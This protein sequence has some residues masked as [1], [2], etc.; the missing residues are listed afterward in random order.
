V[1]KQRKL[2][3]AIA[4]LVLAN[5]GRWYFAGQPVEDTHTK[6]EIISAAELV[7]N[8][9]LAEAGSVQTM[10]RDL[11]RIQTRQHEKIAR[12][13]LKQV[14]SRTEPEKTAVQ[15][16]QEAAQ[17]E[18]SRV[19]LLGVVVRKGKAQAYMSKGT[20]TYLVYAGDMFASRYKAERVALD[21]VEIFDQKVSIRQTIVL[22]GK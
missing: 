17:N 4:L 10:R 20:E 16:E 19:K 5:I 12:P 6:S 13:V 3:L 1:S 9:S 8:A 2:M 14:K 15:L 11:F 21:S 7:L 18:L 22:S